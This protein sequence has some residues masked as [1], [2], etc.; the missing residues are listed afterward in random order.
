MKLS[1]LLKNRLSVSIVSADFWGSIRILNDNGIPVEQIQVENDLSGR[2]RIF[3]KDYAKAL[4]L[5]EK[6]GD[7]LTPIS[8]YGPSVFLHQISKRPV[9]LA[10][11]A[12]LSVFFL[13]LPSRVLY[14]NVEGNVTTPKMQILS[15]AESAGIHIGA[16]RRAIR[17]EKAK[18]ILLSSVPELQWAGVN[19]FGCKAVITVRERTTN[20]DHTVPQKIV[21]SII[22]SRD[23]IIQSAAA[24]NGTLHCQVGQAVKAGQLLISGYTDCG[25]CL[26]VGRAEGEVYAKT[27]RELNL[28]ATAS[29]Q[30]R[31]ITGSK[32]RY[33]LVL[34]KKRINLWK[35]S[36]ISNT[37]CGRIYKEYQLTLP[38][39][40]RMPVSIVCETDLLSDTVPVILSP[41]LLKPDMVS[42]AADYLS[43]QMIAGT[44]QDARYSLSDSGEFFLLKSSYHCLEMIGRE[45]IE[46]GAPNE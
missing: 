17:S 40:Y 37:G 7:R 31:Q 32:A 39:G 36:G 43:N 27:T 23:G 45:H 46:I 26:K 18:N 29:A 15:A 13:F 5:L 33:S 24:Q 4:R 2:I 38:G 22:A 44:I 1:L 30:Q 25:L 8:E 6:R 41:E 42:Y 19:T 11:L 10:G 34:G 3:S 20:T 28:A 12:I 16:S 21:S 14:V 35:G 9:L